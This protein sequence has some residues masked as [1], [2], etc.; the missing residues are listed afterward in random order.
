MPADCSSEV[1]TVVAGADPN[2][3]LSEHGPSLVGVTITPDGVCLTTKIAVHSGDGALLH[4]GCVA[5][6]DTGSSQTFTRREDR[7]LLLGAAS[8]ACERKFVPQS[9]D[10]LGEST[11]LQKRASIFLSVQIIRAGG[12]TCSR[13]VWACAVPPSNVQHTVQL[14]RDRRIRFKHRSYRSLPPQPLGH[15]SFDELPMSHHAPTGVS[16]YAIDPFASD[17]CFHLRYDSTVDVTLSDESQLLAV[18]LSLSNGFSVLT[19]HYP[20]DMQ[21]RSDMFSAEKHLVA[22]GR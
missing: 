18:N 1:L 16:A 9:W 10:G 11:P 5:L 15:R 20:V 14:D 22:S 13:A 8:A 21:P 3:A 6:L 2:F 12:P 4:F 7:T 17:V 19:G